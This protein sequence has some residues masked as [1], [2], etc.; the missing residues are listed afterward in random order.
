[1][2]DQEIQKLGD[3]TTLEPFQALQSAYAELMRVQANLQMI[4]QE[5]EKRRLKALPSEEKAEKGRKR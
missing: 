3:F 5:G 1:M 4:A 2:N